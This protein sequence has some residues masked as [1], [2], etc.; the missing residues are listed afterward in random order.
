MQIM[1]D[2][3]TPQIKHI[4]PDATVASATALP[5]PHMCQGM[6]DGHALPQ[7]RP[8]LR[9]LL[10]FAQLLQQGLIGM[11]TDA[12]PRGAGGAALPQRTL[13]ARRRRELDHAPR[14][15]GHRLSAWTAQYGVLPIQ[16]EGTFRKIRPLS[17]RP[18]LAENGQ[19]LGPLLDQRTGQIGSIN[20]QFPQRALLRRQV[21]LD[22]V[23][24]TGL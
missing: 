1:H 20:M 19:C 13:L 3:T 15:K 11:N 7:L 2:R 18:S 17:Y 22:G 21:R 24:H 14:G 6:F 4:L 8:S 10:A 5:P 9:R 16:L 23:G 12:A